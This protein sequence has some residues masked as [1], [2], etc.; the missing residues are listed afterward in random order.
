LQGRTT[1]SR[2]ANGYIML[3]SREESGFWGR[4]GGDFGAKRAGFGSCNKT[5]PQILTVTLRQVRASRVTIRESIYAKGVK[6][7]SRGGGQLDGRVD[8]ASVK[9]GIRSMI[10]RRCRYYRLGDALSQRLRR[11]SLRGRAPARTGPSDESPQ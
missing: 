7:K 5:L 9:C 11:E 6:L 2:G 8:A 1:S 4:S 3:P 10:D